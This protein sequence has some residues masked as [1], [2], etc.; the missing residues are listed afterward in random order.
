MYCQGS[1]TIPMYQDNG[2]DIMALLP[3]SSI[4]PNVNELLASQQ[5]TSDSY[6]MQI[7]NERIR[8]TVSERE[9]LAQ[10]CYKVLNTERYAYV[11]YSWNYGIEL[12]DLFGKP[13]PYVFAVLPDRIKDCL[14][15]DDRVKSVDSFQL[16]HNK[17]DVLCKFTVHSTF[18]DLELEKVVNIY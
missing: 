4:V 14:I 7:S 8:G 13:I 1:M 16:S 17:G 18:G 6:R 15:Q 12:K 9:A 3:A 2:G 5:E 10:A 11:I